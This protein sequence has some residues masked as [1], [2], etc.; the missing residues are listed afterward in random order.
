MFPSAKHLAILTTFRL[1]NKTINDFVIPSTEEVVFT[2]VHLLVGW[3][4]TRITQ[5]LGR[6]CMKL[7]WRMGLNPD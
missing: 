6:I 3:F 2:R 1:K 5:K 4:V 7:G